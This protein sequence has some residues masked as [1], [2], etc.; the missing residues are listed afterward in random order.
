MTDETAHFD[1]G[2]GLQY[3]DGMPIRYLDHEF[4]GGSF[5]ADGER[6]VEWS[7]EVSGQLAMEAM[8]LARGAQRAREM[9]DEAAARLEPETSAPQA[10]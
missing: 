3:P 2:R 9:L 10:A 1:P 8:L 5:V 6:L 4:P 7:D